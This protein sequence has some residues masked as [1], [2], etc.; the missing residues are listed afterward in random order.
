MRRIS[1]AQT[2]TR[3]IPL[4]GNHF[5]LSMTIIQAF[6]VSSVRFT[7]STFRISMLIRMCNKRLNFVHAQAP[8]YPKCR[9][10]ASVR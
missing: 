6:F 9:I 7:T 2:L 1:R 10:I 3:C 4:S 8:S 5:W